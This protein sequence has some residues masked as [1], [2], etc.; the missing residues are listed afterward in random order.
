MENF[1]LVLVVILF[2][3]AVSDLIVGVSN[4]AVNFL[5]SAIGSKAAPKWIIFTVAAFGIMIGLLG[6]LIH[7][8]SLRS[9]GVP[10]F[11][12][13]APLSFSDLKDVLIRSPLWAM[14]TRPRS[15]GWQD[16]QRQEF[17]QIPHPPEEKNNTQKKDQENDE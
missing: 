14:F 7:I 4:D 13:I 6:V 5:N 2:A 16:P 15:I 8:V 17:R 3:L 1:Y 9:F 12:P 10:Y 11:A